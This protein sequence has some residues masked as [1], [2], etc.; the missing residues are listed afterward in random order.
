[1]ALKDGIFSAALIATGG[2]FASPTG[3]EELD[4]ATDTIKVPYAVRATKSN[5]RKFRNSDAFVDGGT[6]IASEIDLNFEYDA[7]DTALNLLLAAV[8][9]RAK[10]IIAFCPH[11]ALSSGD[12][13][14]PTDADYIKGEY[15]VFSRESDNSPG[16]VGMVSI[17]LKRGTDCNEAVLVEPA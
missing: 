9:S 16:K 17:Q 4:L 12:V 7:A 10:V 5:A 14:P 6:N 8:A 2:T 11:T 15:R 13:I 1:M 3:W